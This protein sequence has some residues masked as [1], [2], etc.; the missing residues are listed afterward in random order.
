MLQHTM[1]ERRLVRSRG[2]NDYTCTCLDGFSG[3][4]CESEDGL[5]YYY[6]R[7]CARVCVWRKSRDLWS[8][9]KMSFI[10]LLICHCVCVC[11]RVC[12]FVRVR[13][14]VCVCV[15]ACLSVCLC[16]Y[17]SRITKWTVQPWKKA[18]SNERSCSLHVPCRTKSFVI[19]PLF[20]KIAANQNHSTKSGYFGIKL[21]LEVTLSH[22]I[23]K[24]GQIF[25]TLAVRFF[26]WTTL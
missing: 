11:A 7:V 23:S 24:Y 4:N 5:Y 3:F 14:R 22:D 15:F 25:S 20:R 1:Y 16:A 17:N 10:P 12:V 19:W 6:V 8:A 21:L 9:L 26:F 2:D 13:A 18:I